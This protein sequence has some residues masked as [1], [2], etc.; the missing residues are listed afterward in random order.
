[1]HQKNKYYWIRMK[2]AFV[3][4]L[5][6]LQEGSQ[7]IHCPTFIYTLDVTKF[8]LRCLFCFSVVSGY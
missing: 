3:A 5:K 2:Q 6:L 7:Q 8:A 1:M 4:S